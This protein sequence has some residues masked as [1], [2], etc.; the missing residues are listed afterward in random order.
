MKL[1][2][3]LLL[4][5]VCLFGCI[6]PTYTRPT[7]DEPIPQA[8]RE[9]SGGQAARPADAMPKGQWWL[10]FADPTLAELVTQAATANQNIATAAANLRSARAQA[11]SARSAFFPTVT[12]SGSAL[13]GTRSNTSR[14]T[15]SGGI[16]AQWEI[17]FWNAL[18]AYEA[19]RA[20]VQATAA[21]YASMRLLVQAETAQNYFQLRTLDMQHALYESTIAA[22]AKAVQLTRSQFREGM[23]TAADVAQAETQLASAE[24]QLASLD[25]QRAALEHSLAVLLG[26]LPSSFSLPRGELTATLPNIPAGLPGELLERRPDIAGAERRVAAANEMIGVARAAW[27]PSVT[28]GADRALTGDWLR[29][30]ATAWSLGPSA[31]LT[32]FEGGK[33]LADSDAAWADYEAV[34]AEY[35]QTVLQAFQDVEDSLSYLN[36]L[37]K[38]AEA[39]DRAVASSETALRLSLSQYRGGMTTYLQVVSTQTA[40]L[41]NRRQA[42]EIQGQRLAHAV[43]LI[44]ALGGGFQASELQEE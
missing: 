29:A 10:A 31:A 39:Q 38:Q 15:Y 12:T 11:A 18:P 7:L 19:A 43:S 16:S 24:A 37:A 30:P 35:R 2:L 36:W 28:L 21:D 41:T 5:V 8:Y 4:P 32:L 44:K 27:F 14:A 40:A 23:V 33:R 22:Y 1:S 20:T 42:I 13:R 3:C 17:G 25:G 26:R 9:D 6:S 34:A